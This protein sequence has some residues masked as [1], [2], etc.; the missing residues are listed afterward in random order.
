MI[1]VALIGHGYWGKILEKYIPPVFNLKCICDSKSDLR[2][3]WGDESIGA[4]IIAVRNEHRYRITKDALLSGKSVLSEKPVAMSL[5]EARDLRD[6]A[7]SRRL[8]LVT[9]YT[10]T[11]S[12]SLRLALKFVKYN[13]IGKLLGMDMSVDHLGPFGG[14]SVYW[15]LG[16]HMLSVLGMFYPLGSLVF[17]KQD[18]VYNGAETET[19]IILF[20][21][22]EFSGQIHLSLNYP[23]K[24]VEVVLYGTEGTMVYNSRGSSTL[25]LTRYGKGVWDRDV[26]RD[27]YRDSIDEGNNLKYIMEYFNDVLLGKVDSNIDTAVKITQILEELHNA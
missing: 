15:I 3:V 10:F 23:S 12:P 19:G 7:E 21:N 1:N 25:A 9:D 8:N 13:R 6:L 4:V 16:S 20:H 26:P 14:G 24:R 2:A 22:K 17:H 11:L 27:S 5:V 18:I